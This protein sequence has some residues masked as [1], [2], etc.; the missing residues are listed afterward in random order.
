MNFRAIVNALD[1]GITVCEIT[2]YLEK[3]CDNPLPDNVRK[4]LEDWER[5]SER[6]R[7]RKITIVETDDKYL[8]EELKSY[9]SICKYIQKELAYAAEIN[10]KASTNIKREIEKKNHFCIIE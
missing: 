9:K 5:E 3:Y 4:T 1:S 7:I 8:M 2:E 6:I 10:G